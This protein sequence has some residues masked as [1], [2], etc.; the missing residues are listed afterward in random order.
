MASSGLGDRCTG[1]NW[2]TIREF[3][4]GLSF[5]PRG[6]SFNR[7]GMDFN[8]YCFVELE[9]AM[10]FCARFDG[11]IIDPKDWPKWPRRR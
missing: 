10:L 3:C 7:D 5:C 4:K 6:H 9:H 8:V 2:V 11:E 1:T